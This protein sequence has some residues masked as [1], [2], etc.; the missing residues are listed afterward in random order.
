MPTNVLD[1]E[2]WYENWIQ[3]R[4]AFKLIVTG[5][6]GENTKKS[7]PQTLQLPI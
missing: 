1:G 2:I 5:L 6:E 4:V 3:C 7:K